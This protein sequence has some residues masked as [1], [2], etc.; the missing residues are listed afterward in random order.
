[1]TR[2]AI[3]IVQHKAR[4]RSP[5]PRCVAL[6][7]VVEEAVVTVLLRC[8]QPCLECMD[9]VRPCIAGGP[10][11]KYQKASLG[12]QEG[13]RGPLEQLNLLAFSS[14][15]RR[16][17]DGCGNTLRNCRILTVQKGSVGLGR[18]RRKDINCAEYADLPVPVRGAN[19]ITEGVN[20]APAPVMACLLSTHSSSTIKPGRSA[21]PFIAAR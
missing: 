3:K 8:H 13:V 16:C 2:T 4:R 1:M 5:T 21:A 10:R 9:S 6:L 20:R 12:P 11:T 15:G 7:L 17:M 18:A 19:A 14:G